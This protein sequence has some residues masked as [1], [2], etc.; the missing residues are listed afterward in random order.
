MGLKVA[1]WKISRNGNCICI[2][3]PHCF[4]EIWCCLIDV[5]PLSALPRLYNNITWKQFP[6]FISSSFVIGLFVIWLTVTKLQCCVGTTY[7]PTNHCWVNISL[8][9]HCLWYFLGKL[10]P[11]VHLWYY[12]KC[13]GFHQWAIGTII[14]VLPRLAIVSDY[15]FTWKSSRFFNILDYDYRVTVILH[16]CCLFLVLKATLQ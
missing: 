3:G 12:S 16:K 2:F 7:S 11:A 10:P 5:S 9:L 1:I 14:I 6:S 8:T 15:L 13:K 4:P